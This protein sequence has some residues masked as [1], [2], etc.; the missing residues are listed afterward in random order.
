MSRFRFLATSVL[1]ALAA[2]SL[3]QAQPTEFLSGPLRLV[4]SDIRFGDP[5]F[6]TPTNPSVLERL[7]SPA[8]LSVN[9]SA[10]HNRRLLWFHLNFSYGWKQIPS[11]AAVHFDGSYAFRCTSAELPA[12]GFTEILNS[13]LDGRS[14]TAPSKVEI[15]RLEGYTRSHVVDRFYAGRIFQDEFGLPPAQADELADRFIRAAMTCTV[16]A[17]VQMRSVEQFRGGGGVR[18]L[19]VFGD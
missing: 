16:H 13:G 17:S 2:A 18:L 8:A 11:P 19:R 4:A 7:E 6:L 15:T 14:E 1:F 3:V 12:P 10:A 5:V 9:I